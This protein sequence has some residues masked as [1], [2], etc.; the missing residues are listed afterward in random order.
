MWEY[1]YVSIKDD[2]YGSVDL[3]NDAGRDGWRFTGHTE[4]TGYAKMFL[5]ERR[6][7]GAQPRG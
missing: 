3:L 2:L 5:M 7:D 6:T 1:K 4:D